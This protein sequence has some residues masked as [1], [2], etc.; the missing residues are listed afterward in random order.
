[1]DWRWGSSDK[2]SDYKHEAL[3]SN[4]SLTKKKRFSWRV[5]QNVV[6]SL[7]SCS[8]W[9]M[10]LCLAYYLITHLQDLLYSLH[11]LVI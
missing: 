2:E 6:E 1:M 11:L 7:L 3:S 9:E 8:C 4:S 5:E 10:N